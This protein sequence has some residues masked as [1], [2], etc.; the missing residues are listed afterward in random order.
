M[1]SIVRMGFHLSLIDLYA[2]IMLVRVL[3]F[4]RYFELFARAR[5]PARSPRTRKC[6]ALHRVI[7]PADPFSQD[8]LDWRDTSSRVVTEY[9]NPD[10]RTTFDVG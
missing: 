4:K 9:E 3:T 2:V 6:P 5:S 1:Q 10:Q 7:E 8:D